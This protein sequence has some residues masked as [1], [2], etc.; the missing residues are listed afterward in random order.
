MCPVSPVL[1]LSCLFTMY[2]GPLCHVSSPGWECRHVSDVHVQLH[3]RRP[4]KPPDIDPTS[5]SSLQRS[6]HCLLL[7]LQLAKPST[8]FWKLS[9]CITVRHVPCMRSRTPDLR[10]VD[11]VGC[12]WRRPTTQ[13]SI[14]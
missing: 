8:S 13:L 2:P 4:L 10:Y 7:P 14:S 3:T 9:T 11:V 12:W 1:L 5:P 6:H